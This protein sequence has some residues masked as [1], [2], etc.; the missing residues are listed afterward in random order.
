MK[1]VIVAKTRMGSGACIG[2]ITFDGRSVRLVAADQETNDHFNME[3]N[4]GD[5]WDV[6]AVPAETIIPPHVENMVVHQK[7]RLPPLGNVTAF[8]ERHMPPRQGGPDVLYEGLAQATSTGAMYIAEATGIPSCST[9]FW[10]PDRP[11]V[12]DDEGKRIR[13][14]YPM[15]DGGRTLTFV[16]FQE[17]I[18]EIPAG[19]LLRVSLAHWWRPP[20]RPN[21]ELRCHVQLSCWFLADEADFWP[22]DEVALPAA[23]AG[24]AELPALELPAGELDMATAQAALKR[25]FGFD[26]F[27]PLQAE[28]IR[29]LLEKRDSLAV[30]PTG[31]GKSL[32]YQLPALLFPGLTVVVSPLI[33]LMEDQV[34]QLRQ[35]GVPAVFLNSTLSYPEYVRTT[36][37]IRAGVVKL[38]YVA[39]ET[40]LRP[41]TLLLLEQCR[42]D[43][44][45]IDE[46][47]CISEWGHDFRPE[48]RQLITVR[49][50]LPAAV[51]LAVTATAT[52]RVRQDIKNSL[53]IADADEF[54]ASF[55]R[56]NLFLAVEPK[57]DG[58]AQ[59]LAFLE[60]RQGQSGIIY[61][62]TR[63]QVD[64]LADQ[65]AARG[66]PVLP[67]HAGLDDATRRQN[68][69]RFSHD[70]VPIMVATI[71]F[72]MGINKSNIRFILH[73]N[74]PKSLENYYQEIGR[75]GRDGLPAECL[76]LFSQS[77]VFTNQRFIQEQ[78]SSQQVGASLRLQAL[79]GF[80]ESHVCRRRPLLAYF[81]ETY[82]ADSCSACDNCTAGEQELVDLT[83]PA[84]KFLSCV[85]RTGE[86]FGSGH[87]IDVLRGSQGERILQRG[88]DRLSTYGIGREFSKKEWRHLARQFIQQGLALQDMEHGSL[89]LTAKAYAVFK[90]EKVLGVAPAPPAPAVHAQAPAAYDQELFEL[91]RARRKELADAAGVPPYVV[92]SD[93]SLVEMAT[94]FP[95]SPAAFAAIYGVGAAKQERYG[96]LFLE[97]IRKYCMARQIAE[98]R[99]PA[100]APAVQ[101]PGSSGKGRTEEVAE[102]YNAGQTV[103]EIAQ[104]YG[105]KPGTVLNH[106]WNH[107]QA[108]H[109]L[110]A[111]GI[112]ELSKLSP[113]TQARVSEAFAELG[114]EYLRP[115]Y[116]ALEGTVD[117][118]ELK[119]MRLYAASKSQ[120]H[121]D[122]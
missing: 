118:D 73:Y 10:R 101:R 44:L 113:E 80:A 99:R 86:L 78:D 104:T 108:G 121:P 85:K 28:I 100:A 74:L 40:L 18:D 106:L 64:S 48:Y 115:V 49:R 4:V 59:A 38:L 111:D 107:A 65:L 89:K 26:A 96:D 98:K 21:Q 102:A 87:I 67:Y 66:W 51:C 5:V 58:L 23:A 34:M 71:A 103:T 69:R 50:R 55:D 72:G 84:Q 62:A 33:S 12:R 77:D 30:M 91:L 13:Y 24:P 114:T 109:T 3:Y 70:D 57:T 45:T 93:R 95:Q 119:I 16:G 32:C 37:Q 81:G 29:N 20:E 31:S 17:P 76:L 88:H 54:M 14:R 42:V 22:A 9:L 110:R 97:V 27:R 94:Y 116:D 6:D 1:V 63:R 60:G 112:L 90:G 36:A 8:A 39:P 122:G 43:C 53:G 117:Y 79:V 75:A 35:V 82:E 41:E 11:L 68:Q 7:R 19:T 120:S 2:G 61:C 83:I 47:H 15:A 25:V 92:F 46:A 105:V 52:A 56:E